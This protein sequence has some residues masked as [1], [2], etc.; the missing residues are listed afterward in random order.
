MDDQPARSVAAP[1]RVEAARRRSRRSASCSRS[2]RSTASRRRGC[3]SGGSCTT[4]SRTGADTWWTRDSRAALAAAGER[5]TRRGCARRSRNTAGRRRACTSRIDA[6]GALPLVACLAACGVAASGGSD[7]GGAARAAAA[8]AGD[9]WWDRVRRRLGR[10]DGVADA[11]AR[12]R[13]CSCAAIRSSRSAPNVTVPVDAQRID[14]HGKVLIPGLH[15]MHV[16]L[17]G[18]RG[19]LALFVAHG[20]TTVRN[21]AGS[22]RTIALRERVAKGELLGPDDLHR[23]AVRRRA[24]AA[25][26]GE[27][28][29]RDAGGCRARDRRRRPRP[30]TTSSRSTTGCRSSAYDAVLAA[31]RAHGLRRGRA[32]AVRGAARARARVAGRR[33]IEHLTGY[34]EAIER[35][36]LAGAPRQARRARR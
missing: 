29:G 15:D 30:A 31:A 3:G 22:P 32:R 25:V 24:A 20:V 26:G 19:M 12:I 23:R 28:R 13:P 17:D 36:R 34:A 9:R 8:G 16:H 2:I 27:R 33:S 18:T 5:S 6:C 21:M 35:E 11:R 1:P 10:D 14:G 7:A 4:C